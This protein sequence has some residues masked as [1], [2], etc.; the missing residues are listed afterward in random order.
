MVKAFE[1][2]MSVGEAA[3]DWYKLA[4]ETVADQD[5]SAMLQVTTAHNGELPDRWLFP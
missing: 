2:G 5:D 4:I 1:V 3:Y